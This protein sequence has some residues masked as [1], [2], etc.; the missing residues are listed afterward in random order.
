MAQ[1]G[2]SVMSAFRSL[3]GAKQTWN[4]DACDASAATPMRYKTRYKTPASRLKYINDFN[5]IRRDRRFPLGRTIVG[6]RRQPEL[7]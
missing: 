3:S 5:I 6:Y 1:R 2:P 4:D 7:V